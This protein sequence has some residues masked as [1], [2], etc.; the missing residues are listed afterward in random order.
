MFFLLSNGNYFY[1]FLLR[2]FVYI[3]KKNLST[4]EKRDYEQPNLLLNI[5]SHE[6]CRKEIFSEKNRK[7]RK[8]SWVMKMWYSFYKF[9]KRHSSEGCFVSSEKSC[10]IVFEEA[11]KQVPPK[12]FSLKIRI[13]SVN[14]ILRNEE[15]VI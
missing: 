8:E 5:S 7:D 13:E 12:S 2:L 11:N 10:D 14:Q 6:R 1:S 4:S 3:H 9:P 15:R